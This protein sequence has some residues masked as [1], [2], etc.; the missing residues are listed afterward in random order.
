MNPRIL[1]LAARIAAAAASAN[2]NSIHEP[3]AVLNLLEL[4]AKKLDQLEHEPE[5]E[6]VERR[7]MN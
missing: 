5:I 3:A 6:P 7:P 2:P 4:V 1:Q